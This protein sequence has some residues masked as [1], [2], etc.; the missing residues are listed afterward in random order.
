M[1]GPF[2]RYYG[3]KWALS[4]R[5]VYQAPSFGRLVEPFAGSAGY[6]CAHHRREV[7]LLD[8]SPVICGVWRWLLAATPEE[9]RRLPC[10]IDEVPPTLPQEVR[11]FLGFW[12]GL[13]TATPR[14]RASKWA[15]ASVRSGSGWTPRTRDRIAHQVEAIRHWRIVEGG[16]ELAGEQPAT[17]FIDPPYQ[18]RPGSYYPGPRLDYDQLGRWCRTRPGQVIVCEATGARWLPFTPLATVSGTAGRRSTD[19][20][21][22]TGRHPQLGLLEGVG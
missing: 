8:R 13:G 21:W 12:I 20:V 22:T 1:I 9:I 14:K 2:F 15:R 16:Y 6:S 11:W 19:A 5:G 7:V 3:A 18:G 17:W 4:R 10:P